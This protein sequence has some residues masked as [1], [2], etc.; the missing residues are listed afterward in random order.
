MA[1]A[2]TNLQ[3]CRITSSVILKRNP[4]VDNIRYHPPRHVIFIQYHPRDI[5][6]QGGIWN[7][8]LDCYWGF[9]IKRLA[10]E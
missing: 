3:R 8:F 5:H 1:L 6:S 9:C 10:E 4:W 2:K 7:Y